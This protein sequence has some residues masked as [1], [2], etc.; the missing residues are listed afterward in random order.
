MKKSDPGLISR[1]VDQCLSIFTRGVTH[2]F[3]VISLYFG[4]ALYGSNLVMNPGLTVGMGHASLQTTGIDEDPHPTA[5]LMWKPAY[6]GMD[7]YQYML[8]MCIYIYMHTLH[9]IALHYITLHY[10]TIHY[11]TIHYITMHYITIHYS[12]LP[13]MHACRHPS[14]H[15]YIHT[16]IERE[17]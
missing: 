4:G 1:L 7:P 11:I 14:I 2:L 16:Y 13:Y 17:R 6:Q 10:I 5:M 9:Y 3:K 12:T 8:I 15:P